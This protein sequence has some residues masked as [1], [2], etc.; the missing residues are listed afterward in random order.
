MTYAQERVGNVEIVD[1]KDIADALRS[2]R[3][4]AFP[5]FSDP[6]IKYIAVDV[7][8]YFNIGFYDPQMAIFMYSKKAKSAGKKLVFVNVGDEAASQMRE[9]QMDV[10]LR[11]HGFKWTPHSIEEFLKENSDF[12]SQS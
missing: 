8:A 2:D 9:C 1:L 12:G 4:Y 10:I 7:S 6:K 3:S 5:E 11:M